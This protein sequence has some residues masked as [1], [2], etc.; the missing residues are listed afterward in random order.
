[1]AISQTVNA[2]IRRGISEDEARRLAEAGFTISTLA[3]ASAEEISGLVDDPVEV[4]ALVKRRKKAVHRKTQEEPVRSKTWSMVEGILSDR[5]YQ[6][7]ESVISEL[8]FKLEMRD[9]EDREVIVSIVDQVWNDYTR[10][11]VD[12]TEA[13]GIVAAQS[14]GEPGTQ[15]TM[16]TFHY[17]GVAEINVTLGLPRLIE[18]VDAR[19]VPSTPMM[20]IHLKDEIKYDAEK[21]KH[22]ASVIEMTKLKEIASIVMKPSE[23][24]V[25]IRPDLE[26]VKEKEIKLERIG[27]LLK[28]KNATVE[29]RGAAFIVKISPPSFRSLQSYFETIKE[30]VVSGIP[31]IERAIIRKERGEY[32]IYTEGSNL[33]QVLLLPDVDVR[34]TTTNDIQEIASVLG[35]E[36]ARNAIVKEAHETLQEQGLNVD[37]RHIMLVADVMTANGSVWAIGRHGVSGMKES[38]LSRAAFEITTNHLLQAAV[39]GEVD[40]LKGVAENIIIGQPVTIGTGA[41]E[42]IY[43]NPLQKEAQ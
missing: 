11:L 32:V 12:P 9:V 7:P 26:K 10:H 5:G 14:I 22:L 42:L 43:R 3:K 40:Q 30:S 15:M 23:M 41:V 6:L 35:I 2:L 21:V 17:A 38:V 1:M 36:A 19:S 29:K 31:K 37:I 28:K 16:R 25:E 33:K 34:N 24:V 39:R 20:E 18:I 4:I 27:L 13:V 8:V